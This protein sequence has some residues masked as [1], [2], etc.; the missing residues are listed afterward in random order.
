MLLGELLALALIAAF[1]C[2]HGGRLSTFSQRGEGGWWLSQPRQT[3]PAQRDR[4]V[5]VVVVDGGERWWWW[6]W[7]GSAL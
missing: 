3:L 6:W 1:I 7:V 2:S 4:S 5:A